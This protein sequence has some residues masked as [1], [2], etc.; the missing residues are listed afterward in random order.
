MSLLRLLVMLSLLP[1]LIGLALPAATLAEEVFFNGRD[2]TGWRGLNAHWAVRDGA[3]VGSSQP[4]G[5]K[6]NTF[7]VSERE[8]G[9]FELRFEVKLEGKLN[10]NSGVQIRS[11]ILDE[12][13]WAVKGPQ[14]DIGAGYWGSLF[15]EHF[16]PGNKHI[17]LKASNWAE[18]KKVLKADDF[19]RYEIRA[20]GKRV[21]IKINGLTTVDDEFPTLPERGLIA[22][23]LHG[24]GPMTVTFRSIQ[25]KALD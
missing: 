18:V 3:L 7:L 1:V 16:A 10:P 8:Y 6:F 17:M 12:K 13:T 24:G 11:Q 5:L 4:D 22:W 19:N 21:T 2:L 23:Q 15:G 25:F 14:C 9:D 20:V